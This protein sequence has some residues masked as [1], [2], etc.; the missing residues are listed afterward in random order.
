MFGVSNDSGFDQLTDFV[1]G[2]RYNSPF[3]TWVYYALWATI[4]LICC[5]FIFCGC[6]TGG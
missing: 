2:D 4:L 1:G 3:A 6:R 5:V